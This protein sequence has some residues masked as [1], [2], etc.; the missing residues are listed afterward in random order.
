MLFS[1]R[2]FQLWLSIVLGLLCFPRMGQCQSISCGQ[3]IAHTTTTTS[4]VDQYSYVGTAGQ[5]LAV[6][7]WSSLSPN[8]NFFHPMV[9]DIYSPSGQLLISVSQ[10]EYY[11]VGSGGG[12]NL[13]LTNTG[14]YT[15]LVNNST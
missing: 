7:L 4:E 8:P 1:Q 5:V 3:T 11:T 12:L 15:I 9:A 2:V 10:S 6:S 14:T 13:A